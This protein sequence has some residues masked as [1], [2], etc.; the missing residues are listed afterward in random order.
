MGDLI[1]DG[2]L[3]ADLLAYENDVVDRERG[4]KSVWRNQSLR[5][6]GAGDR[7]HKKGVCSRAEMDPRSITW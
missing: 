7:E 3:M 1:L 2:Y 5:K 6:Q 4:V